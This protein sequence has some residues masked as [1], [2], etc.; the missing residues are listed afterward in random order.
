MQTLPWASYLKKFPLPKS[1]GTASPHHWHH[2]TG[3]ISLSKY[4]DAF[5]ARFTG[6]VGLPHALAIGGALIALS[7]NTVGLTGLRSLADAVVSPCTLQQQ[8]SFTLIYF[9]VT[10]RMGPAVRDMERIGWSL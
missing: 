6:Y 7:N 1:R 2:F 4:S 9:S 8:Q 3:S 5:P 10:V